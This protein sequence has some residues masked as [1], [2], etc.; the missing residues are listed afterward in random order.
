MFFHDTHLLY[1]SNMFHCHIHDHQGELLCPLLKTRYCYKVVNYDFYSSYA[2]NY[3][4][5]TV[6]IYW[7]CKIYSS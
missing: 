1:F 5:T 4:G 6:H 3:K 7:S 2:V